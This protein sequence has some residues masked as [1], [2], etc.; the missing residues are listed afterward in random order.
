MV[1]AK[2]HPEKE[3][4]VTNLEDGIARLESDFRVEHAETVLENIA[5]EAE[6]YLTHKGERHPLTAWALESLC[7]VIGIPAGFAQRIPW[8]LLQYNFE[9]LKAD[10][11]RDV[12]LVLGRERA[13]INVIEQRKFG[14][15][16]AKS[17]DVLQG[18]RGLERKLEVKSLRIADRGLEVSFVDPDLGTLEPKKGDITA[19]GLRLTNSETGYAGLEASSFL[20]RVVCTNGAVLR[21]KWGGTTWAYDP[22]M[23]YERSLADFFGQLKGQSLAV[24][25]LA[26][27][28]NGMLQKQLTVSGLINLWRRVDR[29]TEPAHADS[30]LGLAEEERKALL[31]GTKEDGAREDSRK[32]E[33]DIS[34]WRAY[35]AITE[36]AR[37]YDF[38]RW[39]Q[40]ERLGGE[41]I[42]EAGGSKRPGRTALPAPAIGP[43]EEEH[44]LE[45]HKG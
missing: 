6:G 11:D 7:G 24:N 9:Q 44:A 29:I 12:L 38:L 31:K 4:N 22:R 15:F 28:Y 23:S 14:Y 40:L 42:D 20:W 34:Y 1:L 43:Q 16:P 2:L 21:K 27:M 8:D 41:L 30:I 26:N 35:N 13:L 19:I 45:S 25:S 17:V 37:A 33:T 3:A 32:Q 39:R 5:L 10:L 36:R 18:L